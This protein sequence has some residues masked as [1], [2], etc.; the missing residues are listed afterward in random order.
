M[1]GSSRRDR[2]S[3]LVFISFISLFHDHIMGAGLSPIAWIWWQSIRGPGIQCH[4]EKRPY[5]GTIK[6]HCPLINWIR[7]KFLGLGILRHETW[8]WWG[9]PLD[10]HA[11]VT[12]QVC[13]STAMC[14][15]I[16]Y[17]LMH[18][19]HHTQSPWRTFGIYTLNW[20][21]VWGLRM[22]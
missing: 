19:V 5:Q 1:L 9:F 22:K 2:I 17:Q 8:H 11:F 16:T 12:Y 10:S 15:H 4:Q 20:R 6:H 21:V 3:S 18:L 14:G 13:A 7:P